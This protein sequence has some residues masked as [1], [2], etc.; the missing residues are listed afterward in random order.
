MPGK[1]HII[2]YTLYSFSLCVAV[3]NE[4]TNVLVRFNEIFNDCDG[5]WWGVLL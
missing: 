3:G 2:T 5:G 1:P 4:H